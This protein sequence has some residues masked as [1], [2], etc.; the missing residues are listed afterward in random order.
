[1]GGVYNFLYNFSTHGKI[2]VQ[3]SDLLRFNA[4]FM[5]K[6]GKREERILLQAI[7]GK[8]KDID[9]VKKLKY[10]TRTAFYVRAYHVL[11]EK[12]NNHIV[13]TEKTK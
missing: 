4:A 11:K 10:T 3:R 9:A 8:M 6:I 13:W 5:K 7:T 1:M 12:Y 2:Y